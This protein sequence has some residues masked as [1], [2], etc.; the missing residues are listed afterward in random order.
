MTA[1]SSPSY[2]T[3]SRRRGSH[4]V[5]GVACISL[6]YFSALASAIS[7]DLNAYLLIELVANHYFL[8]YTVQNSN[9]ILG[10]LVRPFIY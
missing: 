6:R 3:M 10:K 9:Y 1:F 4:P 7:S 8:G 5:A 2:T